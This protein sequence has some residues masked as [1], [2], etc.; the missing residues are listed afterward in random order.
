MKDLLAIAP[1]VV[2]VGSTP[3]EEVRVVVNAPD[4]VPKGIVKA[5]AKF[6]AHIVE[7]LGHPMGLYTVAAF[8]KLIY[9]IVEA[10]ESEKGRNLIGKDV[11]DF[12]L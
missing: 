8:S 9:E 3:V 12:L 6:Q 11:S 4:K 5:L 7:N 10:V 1:Q 2:L